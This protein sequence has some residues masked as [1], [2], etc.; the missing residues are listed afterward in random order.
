MGFGTMGRSCLCHFVYGNSIKKLKA[1]MCIV[2]SG[3]PHMVLIGQ[4]CPSQTNIET[5]AVV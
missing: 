5:E 3:F 2:T 1:G 4:E